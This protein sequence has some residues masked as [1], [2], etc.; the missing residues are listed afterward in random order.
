MCSFIVLFE[1]VVVEIDGFGSI[2]GATD[3]KAETMKGCSSFV[4]KLF[5][6]VVLLK[7]FAE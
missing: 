4:M 3:I 1:L 5:A 7:V 6:W 2:T